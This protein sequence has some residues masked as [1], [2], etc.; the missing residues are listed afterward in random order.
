MSLI[1]L[2]T[3]PPAYAG[4]GFW[5]RRLLAYL[6]EKGV[7]LGAERPLSPEGRRVSVGHITLGW[8]DV[9]FDDGLV[10]LVVVVRRIEKLPDW[11]GK[12]A[13]HDEHHHGEDLGLHVI[14]EIARRDDDC[15]EDEHY[16]NGDVSNRDLHVFLLPE[17]TGLCVRLNHR[18][19]GRRPERNDFARARAS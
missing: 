12:H 9:V 15:N 7:V 10:R 18:G 16:G 5:L 11:P 4:E 13:H 3:P 2:R 17:I 6:L 14:D 19:Q 8:P 1:K